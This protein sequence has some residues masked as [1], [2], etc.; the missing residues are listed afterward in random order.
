M[1]L[2]LLVGL[3]VVPL[4]TYPC[5]LGYTGPYL[6]TLRSSWDQKA[7]AIQGETLDL[8]LATHFPNSVAIMK[9]V[10]PAAV[11]HAKRLD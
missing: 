1:L 5:Q 11:C 9:E 6:G 3:S 7:Y 10:A 2:K 4:T 8:L